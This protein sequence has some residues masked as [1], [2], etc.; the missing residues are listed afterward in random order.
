MILENNKK[1]ADVIIYHKLKNVKND[2]FVGLNKIISEGYKNAIWV[3]LDYGEIVV[4]VFHEEARN[5]YNLEGLWADAKITSIDSE[6]QQKTMAE[7]N[8]NSKKTTIPKSPFGAGSGN[9]TGKDNKK[10]P[11]FNA[12]WI[13]G[14]IAVI[15]I[16]AQYYISNTRGPVETT[17]S[18]VKSTML[19]SQDIE[20]IVVVNEKKANVYLKNNAVQNYENQLDK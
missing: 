20:R 18:E 16:V 9:K 5:F 12:Y 10:P 3:L 7:N 15:F 4:H 17:W 14:I 8:N 2:N 1:Y 19:E 13:Y 6:N 11:K